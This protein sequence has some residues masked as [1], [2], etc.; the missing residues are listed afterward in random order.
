MIKLK[1][2][3]QRSSIIFI[4]MGVPHVRKLKIILLSMCPTYAMQMEQMKKKKLDFHN[5]LA[6]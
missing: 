5:H 3:V 1:S 4:Y 2:E 6:N